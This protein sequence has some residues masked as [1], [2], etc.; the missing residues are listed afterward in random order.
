[1]KPLA[2]S[3]SSYSYLTYI[4]QK[5]FFG[6]KSY[7]IG[8]TA[9]SAIFSVTAVRGVRKGGEVMQAPQKFFASSCQQLTVV[10]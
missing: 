3:Q 2:R 6:F 10:P 4:I 5:M 8:K 9:M 1:M 7:I